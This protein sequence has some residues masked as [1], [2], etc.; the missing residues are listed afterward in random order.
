MAAITDSGSMTK[1]KSSFK[2]SDLLNLF[3]LLST[4]AYFLVLPIRNIEVRHVVVFLGTL[5]YYFLA[6]HRMFSTRFE[7][8]LFLRLVLMLLIIVLGILLTSDEIRWQLIYASLN[9]YSFFVFLSADTRLTLSEGI[10]KLS[11]WIFLLIAILLLA[12]SRS[13]I[14]YVLEDG[15]KTEALVLGMT[16]PNLTAMII[17]GVFSMLLIHFDKM[18]YKPIIAMIIF[19]LIYLVWLTEARSVFITIVFLMIYRL[20]YKDKKMPKTFLLLI[21]IVPIVFIFVYLQ[22]YFAGLEDFVFMGKDFFSGRENVFMEALG[23][24]QTISDYLFGNVGRSEFTNA[25]NAPLAIMCSVGLF[26]VI[27]FYWNLAKRLIRLNKITDSTVA[28]MALI[29]ILAVCIQTS[30]EA[31]MFLGIFPTS[32]FLYFYFLMASSSDGKII[33]IDNKEN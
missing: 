32:V 23:R 12:Y 8:G 3:M 9:F 26:G 13:S 16:N 18:K 2:L 31:A 1:V 4:L 21:M 6:I 27:L 5:P 19:C 24:L 10:N 28:R 29:C 20:F 30:A 33:F 11:I 14:A 17:F 15:R 7:Q 25:H 22:L